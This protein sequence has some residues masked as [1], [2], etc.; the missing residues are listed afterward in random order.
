MKWG[1]DFIQDLPST[2]SG[3][4]NIITCIDYATKL[5]VAKAVPD[6]TAATV[7]RFVFEN[8][9]CVYGPPMELVSDRASAFMD[10]ILKEYLEILGIHHLPSTPYHPRTNGAVERMHRTLNGILT[11]MCAGNPTNWDV[12][13]HQALFSMNARVHSATGYSPFYLVH[14]VEPRLLGDDVPEVPPDTVDIRDPLDVALYTSRE[15]ASL[16]QNRAAAHFRLKAQAM[17]MKE[18]YDNE[19]V[20]ESQNYQVGD[21]VKMWNNTRTKYQFKWNGPFIVKSLGLNH[22]YYLM[23]PSGQDL[24][25]PIHHDHLSHFQLSDLEHSDVDP[26]G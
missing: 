2:A 4:C 7:A 26:P 21:V 10:H 20:S 11:K 22:S 24:S 15:L 16:G 3:H 6:R 8:I 14:G 5:V 23:T 19:N 9:T 18:R 12:Y 25:S 13:L 17:S 1:I